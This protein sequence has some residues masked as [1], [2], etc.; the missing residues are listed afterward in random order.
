MCYREQALL[1]GVRVLE[2]VE[3]SLLTKTTK[4]VTYG[5][6]PTSHSISIN[7]IGQFLLHYSQN[8]L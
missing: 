3:R 2:L 4:C 5:R 8:L 7:H 6:M 1:Y